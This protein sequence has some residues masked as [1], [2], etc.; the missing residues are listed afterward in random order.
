V[1]ILTILALILS[2]GIC[3]FIPLGG[4][5]YF[6]VKDKK[7][8][9][10]FFIGVF[11]FFISQV[12][13]RVLLIDYV[14]PKAGLYVNM[15]SNPWMYAIFLALSIGLIEELGRYIGF[16]YILKN[17]RTYKDGIT[18]GL[19]HGGIE[20]ILVT[21]ISCIVILVGSLLGNDIYTG[22]TPIDAFMAGFER[23]SAISIQIGLSIIILYGVRENK[24][25][26]LF[27]AI[28]IHTLI[29]VPIIITPKVLNVG[30]MGIEAYIFIWA[31]ILGGFA[32]YAKRLYNKQKD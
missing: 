17:N 29:N 10:S 24:I 13:I 18:Y 27:L 31:I 22:L 16:R 6:V 20:A 14:L 4:L 25:K 30:I 28:V 32:I 3:F 11:I 19:G 1:N 23:L 21:G 5:A 7:V 9:K 8:I 2:I 26:Y 12:V 15:Y